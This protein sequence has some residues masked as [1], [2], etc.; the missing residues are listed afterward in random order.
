M[1]PEN[2]LILVVIMAIVLYRSSRPQRTSVGRMWAFAV[3]LI[4]LAAVSIYGSFAQFNPP[5]WQ[6]AAAVV[7]GLAAGI[8]LGL[9]RGHHTQVSAT[10]R[11]GVMQ[12]GPSWATA[13][14]YVG[15]FV[16]RAVIRLMLPPTSGV[17]NVVGDGLLFFA[18]GIIGATYY[19][20]YRKYEALDHA[21]PQTD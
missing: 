12:L 21:L 6:I 17:G 10:D 5:I 3:I 15:A 9:L 1:T 4:L 7:L 16:G 14:I 18:I 13:L 11:H 2:L 19:A 20:V 8:P